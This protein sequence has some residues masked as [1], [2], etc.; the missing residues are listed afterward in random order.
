M[1]SFRSGTSY[2][3][4]RRFE[5]DRWLLFT[6]N[7]QPVAD[8]L[9]NGSANLITIQHNNIQGN[10]VFH[11]VSHVLYN[12]INLILQT[13]IGSRENHKQNNIFYSLEL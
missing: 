6:S 10:C 5:V 13:D 7:P 3:S 4:V 12:L 9:A 8:N 2:I 11:Q 1:C